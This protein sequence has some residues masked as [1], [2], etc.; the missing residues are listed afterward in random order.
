[1]K[2]FLKAIMTVIGLTSCSKDYNLA[3]QIAAQGIYDSA[4]ALDKQWIGD[5]ESETIRLQS[6]KI[7][8]IPISQNLWNIDKSE[9]NVLNA[10]ARGMIYLYVSK[11]KD[12]QFYSACTLESY[13]ILD[14]VTSGNLSIS[15]KNIKDTKEL[16]DLTTFRLPLI[17]RTLVN[18]P[19][20]SDLLSVCQHAYSLSLQ[21]QIAKYYQNLLTSAWLEEKP[22]YCKTDEGCHSWRDKFPSSWGPGEPLCK[23]DDKSGI[24]RCQMQAEYGQSCSLYLTNN[25]LSKKADGYGSLLVSSNRRLEL[26]CTKPGY[27]CLPINRQTSGL[28]ST[29]CRPELERP[30]TLVGSP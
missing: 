11:K 2:Q 28:F 26:S 7:I 13:L 20:A 22:T 10:D 23:A 30:T 21:E 25:G 4:S 27:A 6:D 12:G 19:K 24:S 18:D 9:W 17:S 16:K 15:G 29:S 1:M 8:T 3:E 5:Q 14:T